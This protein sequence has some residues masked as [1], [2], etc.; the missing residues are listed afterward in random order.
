MFTKLLQRDLKIIYMQSLKFR[1]ERI[2]IA[3]I[4]RLYHFFAECVFCLKPVEVWKTDIYIHVGLTETETVSELNGP[5]VPRVFPIF[6]GKNTQ[7][8]I[9][10]IFD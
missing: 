4:T 7:V 5:E 8:S 3:K 2:D 1:H 6:H 9:S 10:S